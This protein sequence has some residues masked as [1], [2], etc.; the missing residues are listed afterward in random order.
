MRTGPLL[1]PLALFGKIKEY[2]DVTRPRLK[3]HSQVFTFLGASLVFGTFLCKEV[4][5]ERQKSIVEQADNAQRTF[6]VLKR[7]NLLNT[8]V[9]AIEGADINFPGHENPEIINSEVEAQVLRAT[10]GASNI[11]AYIESLTDLMNE[12][13]KTSVDREKLNRLNKQRNEMRSNLRDLEAQ[14]D[15]GV[16][17]DIVKPHVAELVTQQNSIE[18]NA[19]RFSEELLRRLRDE[20]QKAEKTKKHITIWSYVFYSTGFFVG[21]LGQL[22]GVESVREN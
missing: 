22:I 11:D 17:L 21:L 4:I 18:S 1:R 20:K 12:V 15:E 2:W 9:T 16:S 19:R 10:R 6:L 14:D 8:R 7:L 5:L 13:H 3:R